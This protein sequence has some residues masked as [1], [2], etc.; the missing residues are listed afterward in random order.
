MRVTR[1]FFSDRCGRKTNI[2]SVL[3]TIAYVTTVGHV[4]VVGLDGFAYVEESGRKARR[5]AVVSYVSA[6]AATVHRNSCRNPTRALWRPQGSKDVQS[7]TATTL[8]R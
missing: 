6:W 5:A 8:G 7:S 3:Q 4:F 2:T 1:A